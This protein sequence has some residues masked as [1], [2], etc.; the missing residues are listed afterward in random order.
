[1]QYQKPKGTTDFYPEELAIR[2]KIFEKLR[3]TA[4]RY[5]FKEIESPA[6]ESFELLSKKEGDEIKQQIF[7]LEKLGDEKYG[8]RFDLT[9]PAVRMF[10]Q[11]QKSAPKPVKWFYLSRMWRYEQPQMG[12]LREFYQ[13]SAEIFGS[14][15]VNSDAEIIS[16][17][18]D[19]LLALGLK[20]GEFF[21]KLNNRNL[22]EGILSDFI[23]K[24]KLF[25]VIKIIDKKA[26]ISRDEFFREF[27]KL[28]LGDGIIKKILNILDTSDIAKINGKNALT[29]KGISEINSTLSILGKKKDFIKIDLSTARGLAYYTGSVFEIFDSQQKYRSIAGGGRYDNLVEL[30]GGQNTPATGFA[31]GYAT[32]LL[33][34]KD[35][36]LIPKIELSPDYF[37]AIVSEDLNLKAIEI[38]EELRKNYK[39]DIDISGRSLNIQLQYANAINARHVIIVGKKELCEGKVVLRDMRTGNE[40]KISLDELSQSTH[41]KK[42]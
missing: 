39:V 37:V 1:M 38:A 40:R 23:P 19:S 33:I 6:F 31:I 15:K 9:V 3:E 17:A 42:L 7:T 35:K 36:G 25:D 24:D 2:N 16:L 18:I 10:I 12:R 32:L 29:E 11:I 14:S 4:I 5:N 8:L 21:V 30:L 20:K 22:L 28:G 34:L 26:K 27:K 13:F 41:W